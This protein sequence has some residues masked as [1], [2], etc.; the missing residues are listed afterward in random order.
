MEISSQGRTSW[1]K[2]PGT[3]PESRMQTE[4]LD[5][6]QWRMFSVFKVDVYMYIDVVELGIYNSQLK[7]TWRN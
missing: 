5:E 1:K 6:L 2:N 7:K 3:A 4:L